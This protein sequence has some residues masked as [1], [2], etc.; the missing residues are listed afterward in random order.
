MTKDKCWKKQ[1]NDELIKEDVKGE[2]TDH[3]TYTSTL[4]N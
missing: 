1:L 2:G 3:Q 4:I